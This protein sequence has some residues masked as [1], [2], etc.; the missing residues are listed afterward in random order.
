MIWKTSLPF[1]IVAPIVLVSLL[2]WLLCIV[3]A[4]FLYGQQVTSAEALGENVRSAQVAHDLENTIDDLIALLRDRNEQVGALHARITEQLA[5]AQYLA[6]K[7]EEKRLTRQLDENLQR[8]FRTWDRRLESQPDD[9][10]KE[11]IRILESECLPICGKLQEFNTRQIR[12]SEINHRRNVQWLVVGLVGATS[13]GSLAGLLLGYGVARSL[14]QSIYHLSIRIQDAIT[15]LGQDLPDI[16]L[17]ENGDL[18]HMQTQMKGVV[19]EIEQVVDRLRQRERE[20]LHAEQLVAVGQLAAGVAHELRNPL[21]SIKMLVQGTREDARAQ[22]RSSEDLDIIESEIRR[23]EKCLKSLL[24][25]ARPSKP[26]H[27][28]LNLAEPITQTLA[29]VS[30]RA[31]AQKVLLQFSPPA[32]LILVEGD[33][34]QIQ[35][36]LVNLTLNGLDVMPTGGILDIVLRRSDDGQVE[37]SVA[38]TGPGVAPE[39]ASR[40]FEPFVSNKPTGLGLGLVTS[41][42]IAENHGGSLT[43]TNRTEGGVVAV[44]RLPLAP[45]PSLTRV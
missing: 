20:I 10:L 19:R 1:K 26:E 44:L 34:E 32:E 16:A 41:R 3:V 33:R 15:M 40:L 6:D 29:L 35:Q 8:Y 31:R 28:L 36:L 23:M 43:L 30:G 22:G 7:E 21:T 14:S 27:N 42:R 24:D 4:V 45:L 38:D 2:L 11:G 39:I 17:M 25:Y 18:H 13:L 37:I 9:S 5:E 12:E